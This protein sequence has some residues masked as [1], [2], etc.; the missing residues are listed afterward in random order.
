MDLLLYIFALLPLVRAWTF[1]YINTANETTTIHGTEN[2]DCTDI[3]LPY[4]NTASYDPEG[5]LPCLV[6]YQGAK[7]PESEHIDVNATSCRS[8]GWTSPATRHFRS[9]KVLVSGAPTATASIST[10]TQ[11]NATTATTATSTSPST[12]SDSSSGL[13]LS[14]GAIAGIVVGGVAF[15]VL[16]IAAVF[17]FRRRQK[18]KAILAN[19]QD[20]PQGP[21]GPNAT[22]DAEPEAL[23]S[24]KGISE[25]TADLQPAGV[26]P[27][28]GS[29]LAELPGQD[30]PMELPNNQVHELDTRN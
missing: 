14:G 29:Q 25:K 24:S 4:R 1:R 30:P 27:A 9:I 12:S 3:D 13:T 10:A 11:T 7:C 2:L 28:P 26:G 17:F 15:V 16:I 18:Q 23:T 6:I 20:A 19:Q 8:W 5:T 22:G 21:H